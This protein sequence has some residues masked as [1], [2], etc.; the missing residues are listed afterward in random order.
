MPGLFVA[1]YIVVGRVDR[2]PDLART[3][4]GVIRER[5]YLAALIG[6]TIV[7]IVGIIPFF[8]GLLSLLGFGAVMLLM[9]RVF[10]GDRGSVA[11]GGEV[12]RVVP[13]TS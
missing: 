5:P 7:G 11:A 13:A 12:R 1:G 2:R 6:L 4:P 3:S 10:R 8:S 9:W